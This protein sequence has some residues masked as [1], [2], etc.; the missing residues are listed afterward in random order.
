MGFGLMPRPNWK[1]EVIKIIESILK[2]RGPLTLPEIYSLL[3]TETK[4]KKYIQQSITTSRVKFILR[5]KFQNMGTTT[6]K[7]TGNYVLWD[8]LEGSEADYGGDRP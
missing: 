2:Q 4:D 8:I 1:H 3:W 7:G 6:R 5:S